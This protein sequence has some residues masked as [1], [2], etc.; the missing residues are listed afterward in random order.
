[1][2]A[3]VQVAAQTGPKGHNEV[4]ICPGSS[5]KDVYH[6]HALWLFTERLAHA[7]LYAGPCQ[8]RAQLLAGEV[9][10][11]PARACVAVQL[12]MSDRQ[13]YA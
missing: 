3:G 10:L 7:T 4:R 11:C 6:T 1:M 8:A 13:P 12:M 2:L 9:I 5:L